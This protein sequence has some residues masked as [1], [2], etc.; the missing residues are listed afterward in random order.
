M[1]KQ[2]TP[3]GML[4]ALEQ[5]DHF[6]DL[7]MSLCVYIRDWLAPRLPEAYRMSIEQGLAMSGPGGKTKRYRPDARIDRVEAPG[8]AYTAE[9]AI[10]APTFRVESPSQPQRS[11]TIRD[12]DGGLITTIEVLSPANKAGDG[13]QDFRLKQQQLSEQGIHLVELDLLTQGQRRWRDER[14]D[15]ADY[16]LTLQRGTDEIASVW[17]VSKGEALPTIPVPLRAPDADVPLPVE[18]VLQEYLSKSGVGRRLAGTTVGGL[19]GFTGNPPTFP[20]AIPTF[21]LPLY[22]ITVLSGRRG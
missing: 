3:P 8:E 4:P 5:P 21:F 2:Q 13:Y 20:H 19:T 7:H 22:S 15:A 9:I 1:A 12:E 14:V 17:A 10:D 18:R 11:L 6:P 16:V